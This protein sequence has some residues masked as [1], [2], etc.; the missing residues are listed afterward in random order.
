MMKFL[1]LALL[2]FTFVLS[3]TAGAQVSSQ[4]LPAGFLNTT[5]NTF[6]AFPVNTT[7]DQKWQWHYD[8][9]EFAAAGPICI[10]EIW[11]RSNGAPIGPSIF[12][13]FTVSNS[14]GT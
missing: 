1:T 2:A 4:T 9:G 11:V 7:A 5:G 14:G 8:S 12:D 3:G 6:T 10:T 13:S